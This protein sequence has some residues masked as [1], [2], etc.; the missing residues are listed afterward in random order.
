MEGRVLTLIESIGLPEKQE[1][2]TKE[3]FKDFFYPFAYEKSCY[4]SDEVA[5]NAIEEM[6][7]L[8][9]RDG[10]QPFAA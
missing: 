9:A 4:L 6:N 8:R 10:F 2:A 5:R 3:I 1:T 7:K